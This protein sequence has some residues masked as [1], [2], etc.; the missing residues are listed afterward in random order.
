MQHTLLATLLP[1]RLLDCPSHSTSPGPADL[2]L[3]AASAFKLPLENLTYFLADGVVI[4]IT[5]IVKNEYKAPSRP[6]SARHRPG[7]ERLLRQVRVT[8]CQK[9]WC[10]H[11][12]AAC[13]FQQPAAPRVRARRG[14][15][16]R[17]E[18]G[19]SRKAICSGGEANA[20]RH[21]LAALCGSVGAAGARYR[22]A[23]TEGV[24]GSRRVLGRSGRL[25]GAVVAGRA[26]L[27]L[28]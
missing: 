15:L 26:E 10:S 8:L 5:V 14:F 11:G 4:N 3:D 16:A 12:V 7:A 24:V 20:R 6:D 27:G 13:R 21:S 17:E 25:L 23:A 28:A 18:R 9:P 19:A 2:T 22:S 1:L